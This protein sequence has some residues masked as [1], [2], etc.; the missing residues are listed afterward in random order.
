MEV[1]VDTLGEARQHVDSRGAPTF[2]PS[3]EVGIKGSFKE[4]VYVTLGGVR[5]DERAMIRV[6]FNPLVRL[7]WL[8]GIL[9][10]IGGLIVM[11]PLARG[12][13]AQGGYTAK[14]EPGAS[15]AADREL[16]GA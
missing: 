10:A 13:R 1:D 15:P 2:E 9:I 14:M 7:V 12:R 8:G 3:I 6:T 5:G 4:D 11:W 16:V